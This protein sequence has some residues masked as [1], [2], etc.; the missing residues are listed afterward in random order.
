MGAS[1][2][3]LPERV[4]AVK[5]RSTHASAPDGAARVTTSAPRAPEPRRICR[6]GIAAAL[7]PRKGRRSEDPRG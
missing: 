7:L 4:R 3:D 5:D 2:R 1:R 6:P